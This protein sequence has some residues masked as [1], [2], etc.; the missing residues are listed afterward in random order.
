M[1]TNTHDDVNKWKH[2]LRCWPLVRGFHW[3][4]V[5]SSHR[6]HWCGALLFSLICAWLNGWV[7]NREAGDLRRH[8][9]HFD[10]IVILMFDKCVLCFYLYYYVV[11]DFACW[12]PVAHSSMTSADTVLNIMYVYVYIYIYIYICVCVCMCVC[13]YVCMY[14][15][16]YIYVCMCL[17]SG[18]TRLWLMVITCSTGISVS[19][20]GFLFK[21]PCKQAGVCSE[22]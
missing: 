13:V 11:Q 10:V 19:C 12:C 1:M 17:Q 9:A 18:T 14:I 3:S 16:I 21:G 8:H 15:Y 6:D 20:I 5:N 22:Q 4:P 2:F 7:N